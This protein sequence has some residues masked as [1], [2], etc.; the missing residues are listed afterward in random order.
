MINLFKEM[1]KD[2]RRLVHISEL[3]YTIENLLPY[4][5]SWEIELL[6]KEIYMV[7]FK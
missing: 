2:S 3:H 6:A 7:R 1:K 4:L 5:N